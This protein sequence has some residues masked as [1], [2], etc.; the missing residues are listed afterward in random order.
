MSI[1]ETEFLSS[2]LDMIFKK[3]IFKKLDQAL[4]SCD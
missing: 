3:E 2:G 1:V 4:D